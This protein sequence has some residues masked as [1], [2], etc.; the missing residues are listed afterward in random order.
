[1]AR[2][3]AKIEIVLMDNGSVTIKGPIK[4]RLICY[5]MLE[6]ASDIVRSESVEKKMVDVPQMVMNPEGL[7]KDK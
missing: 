3:M 7:R 6:V 2:E 1:M 5:G 4:D